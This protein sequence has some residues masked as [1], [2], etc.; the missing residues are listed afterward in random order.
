MLKKIPY[1][2]CLEAVVKSIKT[3]VNVPVQLEKPAE[4]VEPYI[5]IEL[6]GKRE[7]D[8][9]KM[10]IDVISTL[11]H[12]TIPNVKNQ[13]GINTLIHAVETALTKKIDL[14]E[15]YQVLGQKEV[16][17][18]QLP[19]QGESIVLVVE[20]KIAYGYKVKN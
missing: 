4:E 3:K 17:L 6:L 14:Q 13:N 19:S 15:P 5:W 12:V 10:F 9:E 7:E 20:F 8:T 11:I 2:E 16:A 18:S 1:S